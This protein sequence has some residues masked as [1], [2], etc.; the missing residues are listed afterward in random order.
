MRHL[1]TLLLITTALNVSAQDTLHVRNLPMQA[2]TIEY[3]TPYMANITNDSLYTT[4]LDLRTK[5]RATRPQ[6]NTTVVL[7]SIPAFELA[8]LYNY[9][10]SSPEGMGIS[11]QMKNQL[12]TARAANVYLNRLCNE[13]EAFWTDRFR[14]MRLQGRKLLL[15]RD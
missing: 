1:L 3:L 4:F 14:L 10:L 13:A 5:F 6:G 8:A 12:T 7:D 15:G 9:T 11:N 2:R